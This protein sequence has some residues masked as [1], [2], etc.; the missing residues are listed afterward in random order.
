[1]KTAKVILSILSISTFM[2]YQ[3]I[4]VTNVSSPDYIYIDTVGSPDELFFIGSSL[5]ICAFSF[6]AIKWKDPIFVTSFQL[7][8]SS[9]FFVVTF[10]YIRRWVMEGNPTTNYLTS[11]CFVAIFTV[12]YIIIYYIRNAIIGRRTIKH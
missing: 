4:Y 10:I 6:L 9:F 5:S 7:L 11:L 3:Y 8:C 2:C 12:I 1:M